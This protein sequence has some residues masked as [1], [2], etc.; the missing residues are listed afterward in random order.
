MYIRVEN[1][2]GKS[3][4]ETRSGRSDMQASLLTK[5]NSENTF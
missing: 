5:S 4:R 2:R 1:M 3:Y